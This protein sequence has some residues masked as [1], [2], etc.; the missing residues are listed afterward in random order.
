MNKEIEAQDRL[1]EDDE[2]M[3]D[4]TPVFGIGLFIAACFC[5]IL[6]PAAGIIMA[7]EGENRA[8]KSK[9]RKL[10]RNLLDTDLDLLSLTKNLRPDAEGASITHTFDLENHALFKRYT[11]GIVTSTVN[12]ETGNVIRDFYID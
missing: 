10:A 4:T 8:M 2:S 1:N 7:L 3:D 9:T 5:P 6:A 12:L 11:K